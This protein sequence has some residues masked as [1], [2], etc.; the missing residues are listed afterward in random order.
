LS[1]GKDESHLLLL[2][3]HYR[4]CTHIMSKYYT[5]SFSLGSQWA[6]REEGKKIGGNPVMKSDVI[7]SITSA[8]NKESERNHGGGSRSA[9]SNPLV[10]LTWAL[11]RGVSVIPRSSNPNHIRDNA[12]VIGASAGA[13]GFAGAVSVQQ[14]VLFPEG[15][16]SDAQLKQIDRLDG[17]LDARGL[18]GFGGDESGGG[19]V[20]GSEV[21]ASFHNL[22]SGDHARTLGLYWLDDSGNKVLIGTLK[23]GETQR[24]NTH[25][26]HRFISEAAALA[27]EQAADEG[28]ADAA[29]VHFEVQ[30]DRVLH[31]ANQEFRIQEQGISVHSHK[32]GEL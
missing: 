22:L 19:S 4:L 16:L 25:H 27:G 28:S 26:S 24:L 3:F 10:V 1:G 13:G 29:E 17:Q 21:T 8:M 6:Y 32:H 18:T 5:F 9:W 12:R 23:A 31:G 7:T 11:Q 15:M 20:G 30:V 14:Q 2:I